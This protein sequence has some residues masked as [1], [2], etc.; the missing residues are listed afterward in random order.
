MSLKFR[1]PDMYNL[2]ENS[3]NTDADD[4][5][6]LREMYELIENISNIKY[7][8]NL[9]HELIDILDKN[10]Y[11]Y[12][13]KRELDTVL[14]NFKVKIRNRDAEEIQ[15]HPRRSDK[16]P[17][18]SYMG[19]FA[20]SQLYTTAREVNGPVIAKPFDDG[21]YDRIHP[22]DMFVSPSETR[23]KN[24]TIPT[25]INAELSPYEDEDSEYAEVIS[26][27][28]STV[29]MPRPQESNWGRIKQVLSKVP[30]AKRIGITGYTT[31]HPDNSKS[32]KPKR[33]GIFGGTRKSRKSRKSRIRKSRIRKSRK[34]RN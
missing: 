3:R 15:P 12:Y 27:D 28:N 23:I 8:I 9:K 32:K 26:P 29:L 11:N 10:K 13:N 1:E 18:A 17:T 7:K 25:V 31:K 5:T 19:K 21:D 2:I 33:F 34:S 30:G 20:N 14:N 6:N 22:E 16:F 24:T 4:K